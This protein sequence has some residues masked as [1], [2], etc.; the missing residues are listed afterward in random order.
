MM[1]FSMEPR[2]RIGENFGCVFFY[3]IGNVYKGSIPE[4][5]KKQLQSIGTGLR[6]HTPIGP[7]RLDF[8]F[9]LNRRKDLDGPVQ[10]YFS[11]GQAF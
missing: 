6:Y 3:D 2:F 9:P 5:N 7:L 8:A 11:V 10:V 1:I 4:F